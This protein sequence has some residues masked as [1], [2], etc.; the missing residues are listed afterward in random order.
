[1]GLTEHDRTTALLAETQPLRIPITA[2]TCTETTV[3]LSGF[4]FS[5]LSGGQ[6]CPYR[7]RSRKGPK[8]SQAV[9]QLTADREGDAA[10]GTTCHT[11]LGLSRK[12]LETSQDFCLIPSPTSPPFLQHPGPYPRTN[13]S[14]SSMLSV[15]V[16][17]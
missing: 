2:S 3:L 7:L 5:T 6:S 17:S 4:S 14:M 8:S 9:D 1:M 15:M 16:E 11:A 13:L 12:G 10:R